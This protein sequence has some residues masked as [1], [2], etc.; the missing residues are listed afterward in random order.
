MKLIGQGYEPLDFSRPD[1]EKVF[2]EALG[3]WMELSKSK[4][5]QGPPTIEGFELKPYGTAY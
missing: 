2:T 1:H 3:K 5:P 4:G